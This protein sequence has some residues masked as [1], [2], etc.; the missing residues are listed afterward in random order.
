MAT[1]LGIRHDPRLAGLTLRAPPVHLAAIAIVAR[2][3]AC[4]LGELSADQTI[5]QRP[6]LNL[7]NLFPTAPIRLRS[8][9]GRSGD[10]LPERNATNTAAARIL[11]K[12]QGWL[13]QHVRNTGINEAAAAL[14]RV[15]CKVSLGGMNFKFN[16]HI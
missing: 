1:V 9:N 7:I 12:F 6:Y 11:R 5:D 16:R 2:K 8:A 3:S 4:G 13:T 14:F 15:F 10:Y